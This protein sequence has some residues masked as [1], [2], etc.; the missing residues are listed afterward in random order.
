MDLVSLLKLMV[1]LIKANFNMENNMEKEN[2][3]GLIKIIIKVIGLKVIDRA[4]ENIVML[5]DN[6]IKVIL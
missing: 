6:I 1:I 3:F 4:N 5:T 2:M